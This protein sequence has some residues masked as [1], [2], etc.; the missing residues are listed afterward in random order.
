MKVRIKDHV[1]Q[2]HAL[3][4]MACPE[5]FFSKEEDGHAYVES[6][7]VPA[8]LEEKVYLAQESCPEDAIEIEA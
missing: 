8:G 6:E 5:V 2:G 3:C 7:L 1:C 4:R